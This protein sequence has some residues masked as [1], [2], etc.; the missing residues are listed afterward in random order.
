MLLQD[1]PDPARPNRGHVLFDQRTR[2]PVQS[3]RGDEQAFV[4][5]TRPRNGMQCIALTAPL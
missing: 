2:V 5:G 1:T 4:I 3:E